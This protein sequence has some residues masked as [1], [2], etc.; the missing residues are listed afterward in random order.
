MNSR[1]AVRAYY[2]I[3]FAAGIT[4]L[5]TAAAG[6]PSQMIWGRPIRDS[7]LLLDMA[8]GTIGF[9]VAL[10]AVGPLT[11][12][13]GTGAT[14]QQRLQQHLDR[15]FDRESL[16]RRVFFLL[17]AVAAA[18]GPVSPRER[19]LLRRFL[20]AR[21]PD[22]LT[23]AD[24][25]TWESQAPPVPDLRAMAARLAG[26]LGQAE[27]DSLFYWCCL[28]AFA[29]GGF[30]AEEHTALQQVAQGLGVDARRARGLFHQA[31][32]R[33]L[34]SGGP[35]ARTADRPS[36]AP[37]GERSQACAVLGLDPNATRDQVRRRHRELVK[38]HH[39]DAHP[40]LGPVAAAEA[41][42][43]FLRIQRAYEI[44]MS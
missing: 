38:Q 21:F 26:S 6:V 25:A 19:E 24:L 12:L 5:L 42:E 28:C 9:A 22:P 32:E 43:R 16:P 29:D 7:M 18:D 10:R 8:L 40:N 39:P 17:L 3:R 37:V 41:T 34:G 23:R 4:L 44:L 2:L 11:R 1:T 33:H 15:E 30:V 20:M 35:R 36:D 13:S 14:W 31:R 27:R